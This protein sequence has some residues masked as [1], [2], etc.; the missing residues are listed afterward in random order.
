[1]KAEPLKSKR[2]VLEPLSLKHLSEKYVSWLNDSETNRYLETKGGYTIEKL[3]YFLIEN[4]N[5]NIL[6]WAIK[7]KQD[8]E[9]IGNIKIDPVDWDLLSGEYG[10]LMGDKNSWGKGFAKE[11]SLLVVDYCFNQLGLKKITLGVIHE[12]TAAL[13]L[14]KNLG[15]AVE[16]RIKNKGTY[17]GKLC[18]SI[19]MV[20]KNE[21]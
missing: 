2:L 6:F 14:Y 9:H 10:I 18:D 7:K 19:R 3:K 15:F 17:N 21:Q 5:K 20:L 13:G 11:A 1:M 8:N 4:E 12:N 16:E